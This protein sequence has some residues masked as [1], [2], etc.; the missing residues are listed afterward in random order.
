MQMLP[1]ALSVGEAT[2]PESRFA[3]SNVHRALGGI[4]LAIN[5]PDDALTYFSEVLEL[6]RNIRELA[7]AKGLVNVALD[8]LALEWTAAAKV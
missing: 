4:L 2:Q 8:E 7:T 6:R 5:N 3:L 1:T